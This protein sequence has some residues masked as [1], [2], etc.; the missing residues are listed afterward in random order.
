[1]TGDVGCQRLSMIALL[2]LGLAIPAFF[3]LTLLPGVSGD[4]V[5]SVLLFPALRVFGA[6]ERAS[7]SAEP[8]GH[9]VLATFHWWRFAFL[10]CANLALD[11]LVVLVVGDRLIRRLRSR[12]ATGTP[13]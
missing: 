6:W 8:A 2:S 9:E 1:M 5:V 3:L 12:G 7:G 4:K 11:L 13:R 10:A